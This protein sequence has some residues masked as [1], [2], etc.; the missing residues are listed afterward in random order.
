M[1]RDILE[2]GGGG[3]LPVEGLGA[4]LLAQNKTP[5]T[6]SSQERMSISPPQVLLNQE[7]KRNPAIGKCLFGA[8]YFLESNHTNQGSFN[9]QERRARFATAGI[10][11]K[12]KRP[13][14]FRVVGRKVDQPSPKC[15]SIRR[16]PGSRTLVN[17]SLV[18]LPPRK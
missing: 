4:S 5:Q 12:T 3:Y 18:P 6:L 2:K 7:T 17:G 8:D 13:R 11:G 15:C 1:I 14:L 10:A 16:L 9:A